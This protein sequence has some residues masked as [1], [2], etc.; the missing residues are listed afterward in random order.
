MHGTEKSPAV[1]TDYKEYHTDKTVRFVIKMNPEKLAQAET[2]GGL[3]KLFKITSTISAQNMVLFDKDG[4]I[5]KYDR[6]EDIL[7]EFYTCRLDFYQKRKDYLEGMLSAEALRL[8]NIA[9]FIIE[10]IDG[11]ITV[12]KAYFIDVGCQ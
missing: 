1:I 10:K 7:K 4:C 6:V 11:T 5:R 3:H 2:D 8:S 12:G 9:R